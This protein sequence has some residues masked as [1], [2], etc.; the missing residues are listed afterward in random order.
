MLHNEDLKEDYIKLEKARNRFISEIAKNIHLYNIT[1]SVGRLYGTVF[2]SDKPMTL[3][4]MSESLGMSKTSMSTGIRAL[5]D[6]NMVE[7]VWE[8]GVRKDLYR[9]EEDWYKSFSTVFITRWRNSTEMNMSA[10]KDTKGLMNE[11]YEETDSGH[12]RS[13]IDKDLEKLSKAE[14]YYDWLNEVIA[15]FETGDIFNIVPKKQGGKPDSMDQ[16]QDK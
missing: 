15:L 8:K 4:E 7:Q 10:I 16:P 5:S 1:S 11:L 12:I 14:A 13:E 6:A 3:D 9:T 2:F